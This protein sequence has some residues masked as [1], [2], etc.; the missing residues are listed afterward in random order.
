MLLPTHKNFCK[1][2]LRLIALT[3]VML[4]AA[5]ARPDPSMPTQDAFDPYEDQNRKV[6]EFNRGFDRALI[7]PAAKGYSSAIPD[8]IE[9]LIVRFSTNL[10]LPSDIVNSVLQ[11][12]MRGAIE[13]TARLVVNTTV[14]LGGLFD[15]ASEMGMPAGTNADFGQTL[16]A[17]GAREGAYVELPVLGPS[18]ERD[19]W[20]IAVDLFTNPL[21]YLLESPESL[22]GTGA[23]VAAGLSKRD[24]FSETIDTILYESADSYAQSRS[25]YLQNRRF[26]LGG[27]S[28]SVYDDPYDTSAD[29]YDTPATS[30]TLEDPY[31]E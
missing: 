9:T 2:A 29:P 1:P 16:H 18:T 30:A 15:P 25:I 10:S 7:R 14:G 3:G 23:G 20:G 24:K 4:I 27:T 21:S 26:E 19:T 6:H 11:L 13:D 12:N 28:G 5:C 8:D 17:W 22:I 31:D